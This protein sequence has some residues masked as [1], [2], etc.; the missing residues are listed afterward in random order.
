[1]PEGVRH[2]APGSVVYSLPLE[3]SLPEVFGLKLEAEW[4]VKLRDWE[5]NSEQ[6]DEQHCGGGKTDKQTFLFFP[7]TFCMRR[8]PGRYGVLSSVL[9]KPWTDL[10]HTSSLSA[11][12]VLRSSWGRL[13]SV[14]TRGWWHSVWWWLF[15][16][17]D[18]QSF[19]KKKL[20][21]I[22]FFFLFFRR[23]LFLQKDFIFVGFFF[24][25]QGRKWTA[26]WGWKW[27]IW[28][29]FKSIHTFMFMYAMYTS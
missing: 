20:L 7:C 26:A 12:V 5:P 27:F 18:S 1:M 29:C 24:F 6:V 25:V 15:T 8:F 10:H 16:A 28:M 13:H 23:G 17:R 21:Y 3:K 2:R 4:R 9:N 14:A 19:Q 11:S 22:R